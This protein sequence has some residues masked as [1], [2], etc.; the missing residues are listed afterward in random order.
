MMHAF[1]GT[2]HPAHER[3][4]RNFSESFVGSFFRKMSAKQRIWHL[5][6]YIATGGGILLSKINLEG[7]DA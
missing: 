2:A 4:L 1:F 6:W 3:A 7:L 5:D